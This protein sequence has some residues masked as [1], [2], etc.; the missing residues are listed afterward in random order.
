M[1]IARTSYRIAVTLALTAIGCTGALTTGCAQKKAE[2]P[3]ANGSLEQ[4]QQTERQSAEN[5]AAYMRNK[6]MQQQQ[7]QTGQGQ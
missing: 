4:T 7:G 5:Y 1:V 2:T 3:F 6:Q